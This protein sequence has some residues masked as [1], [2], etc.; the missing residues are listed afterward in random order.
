MNAEP[1]TRKDVYER[2]A[3]LNHGL[4]NKQLLHDTLCHAGIQ[5]TDPRA[6][7]LL[8]A[9]SDY[10]PE[11][12]IPFDEFKP[13]I[14][15]HRALLER[16]IRGGLV[17]PDFQ[18]FCGQIKEIFEEAQHKTEGAV[19]TYIPQLARVNPEH[20]AMALC[21]IDGQFFSLGDSTIPFCAQSV[22]KPINYALALKEHGEKYVH[23]YVGREPSGHHFNH[24]SLNKNGLPH[25][26]LL[27]SGAISVCGMIQQALSPSE[28]FDF[29][30]SQWKALCGGQPVGFNNAVYLSEKETADRNFA[31]GYFLR[32]NKALPEGANLIET[33]EF[34]FQCCSIE[35]NAESMAIAAAS[36]A[37]AGVCP[38]TDEKVLKPSV[39][40]N[41]LSL[42]ASCGMYDF[43]GEFAFS[44]GLPGKSG[45]SGAVMLVIPNVMGIALWSPRLDSTGNSVR[46]IDFCKRLVKRFNFHRYDNL[47]HHGKKLDPR[48]DKN[49]LNC[50]HTAALCWAAFHGDN[51]EI[52]RLISND[53]NVNAPDYDHRTA[54]HIAAAEGHLS[55]VKFLLSLGADK[56]A[57]DRWS[58]TPYDEA[59]LAGHEAV[60][61][62]L[63]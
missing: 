54:L 21:T 55:T 58:K 13:R 16:V 5:A 61:K 41:C 24:L 22:C 14:Q 2:L 52:G 28:R 43:S 10:T 19:A 3:T 32:E 11:A 33:L 8:A 36:L 59:I 47:L 48:R 29:V 56:T 15:E 23:H 6:A 26:P 38:L 4:V 51:K 9:F 37:N 63:Q 31:I 25:N 18:G 44:V 20:F 34:Y 50:H 1:L 45:V 46:G 30:L 17:I 35:L 60:A 49:A 39:V 53:V 27:N 57:R 7:A 62:I 42:M 12:V 40:K